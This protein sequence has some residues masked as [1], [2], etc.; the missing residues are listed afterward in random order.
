MLTGPNPVSVFR[1]NNRKPEPPVSQNQKGG[2]GPLKEFGLRNH[3]P[4]CMLDEEAFEFA[5]DL[6]IG[7][8]CEAL[9]GGLQA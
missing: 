5:L 6:W 1:R 4:I 3:D 2:V 7:V 9:E 8:A